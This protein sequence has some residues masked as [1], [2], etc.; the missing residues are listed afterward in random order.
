[1]E[2]NEKTIVL[3]SILA[4]LF[5]W[6]NA[7]MGLFYSDGGSFRYVESIH[8]VTVQLFGDGVYAN[9]STFIAGIRK[10]TDFVML[11][12]SFGF[13][14]ATL[15]R[16]KG[17]KTKLLHGGLLFAIFYYALTLTFETVFNRLF[18]SYTALLSISFF[19][20]I[21]TFIDLK[22]T[23]LPA[24]KDGQ[25]T[26]TAIFTIITGFSGLVWLMD[27]IPTI[28]SNVPPDFLSIYTTSPTKAID[29]GLLFPMFV[30][31]GIMLLNKK[32]AG[33]F[34]APIM[35]MFVSFIAFVVVGQTAF[36]M[37]FGVDVALYQLIG[38]VVTFI[39]F[40]SIAII[41]NIKFMLRVWPKSK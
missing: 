32:A 3:L 16:N 33:Y 25:H 39:V 22:N 19:A 1:M 6:F 17:N 26:K 23:I 35:L 30:L 40:G 27:I 36:Q 37:I 11:L 13:F 18:L 34:L 4:V 7:G 2:K 29:I 31:C 20:V 12:V 21:Y 9:H 15:K 8:G 38:Y 5:V 14:I 24:N 28:F 10:G 41:V